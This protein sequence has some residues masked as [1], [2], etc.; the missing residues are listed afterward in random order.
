MKYKAL[1]I[2]DDTRSF[3]ATVR[4]LGRGDIEVHVAPYNFASP[5]LAS[6]YIA[7]VHRLPYYLDGGAEWLEAMVRLLTAEK[8]DLIIP[9]EE[10]SLLPLHLHRD[11]LA[12]LA[13]LAIPD[14]R[15]L[16]AFFDKSQT[17]ALA[18]QCGVP[19]AAG[20]EITA[21]T[22]TDALIEKLGLPLI[23]KPR[24]SYEWPELYV[25]TSAQRLDTRE[26][27]GHWLERHGAEPGRH[28]AEAV[29]PGVGLGLSVLCSAGRVVLAFEHRRV[30]EEF[31][32][33]FY[34]KSVGVD[35]ARLRAV[36]AMVAALGYTGLAMF[37]FRENPADGEWILLEVNAR[38]WGSLPL[39]V[40]L[41]VDFPLALF[42]LMV[43]GIEPQ[44][45]G[46]LP[47]R[48]CRNF[49]SDL[50]Q[51]RKK[52][53][54]GGLSSL[55]AL[56]T[57]LWSFRRVLL[58]REYS[59]LRVADDTA[60]ARQECR[61]FFAE[62]LDGLRFRLFGPARPSP[63]KALDPLGT[64]LFICQGNICRSPY[65]EHKLRALLGAV[66][67][68]KVVSAGMLPRNRRPSP[69]QA[70]AAAAERGIDL[71][72]H[73]SQ[74]ATD[75]MIDAADLIIVFDRLNEHALYSRHPGARSKTRWLDAGSE[76][77][78]P[79]GKDKAT[80]TRTYQRIDA[81]LQ[82][83]EAEIAGKGAPHA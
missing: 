48:Y 17:R 33:S 59:D 35:P 79:D 21:Q 82:Q 9:C 64:V 32:S 15:S 49:F 30:H 28:L 83:L 61:A 72:L 63:R 78:D 55:T 40:A 36:Q 11:R 75:A 77:D 44:D 69:P 26:A 46:Y 22:T 45:R 27:L 43:E 62:R 66:S 8:F 51:I 5:A 80:F 19:V 76:I 67:A 65:A 29:F 18:A 60:P 25:R 7:K 16:D 20:E 13:R 71:N 1:V 81:C 42:R 39:P 41:G 53:A 68:I 12:P 38:P 31:G 2:G 10:R 52:L 74:T 56:G 57:W 50:W 23:V 14:Q 58:G 37:E 3:L 73:R 24:H 34:R 70:L 4:S 54:D 47:E 6:G